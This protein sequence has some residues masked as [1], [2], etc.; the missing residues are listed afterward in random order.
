MSL[1]VTFRGGHRFDITRRGH[2]VITDQPIEDGGGDAGMTPVELFIGS[3]STCVGYFVSRYCARHNIA[4]D[5]L[6]IEV[7]WDYAEQPHRVGEIR[8]RLILPT[9]PTEEQ[10]QALLRVAQGCTVHRSLEI[11]PKVKIELCH[12]SAAAGPTASH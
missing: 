3:L 9:D 1:R 11:P 12:G 7:D 8:L 4:T 10:Q 5:G 6:A 2:T